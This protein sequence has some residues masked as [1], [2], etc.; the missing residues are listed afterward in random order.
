MSDEKEYVWVKY[1]TLHSSGTGPWYF[2]EVLK[3]DPMVHHWN[4]QDFLNYLAEQYAEKHN[5]YSEHFRGAECEFA[6]PSPEF[7]KKHILNL[8][9]QIHNRYDAIIRAH[10]LIN[11]IK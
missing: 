9:D 10:K 5:T 6:T 3:I 8:K 1:R 7:L 4:D 11:E 2:E